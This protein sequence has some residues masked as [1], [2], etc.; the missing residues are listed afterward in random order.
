MQNKVKTPNLT[1]VYSFIQ[2]FYWMNFS[3]VMGFASLYLLLTADLPTQKL[4]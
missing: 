1:F 3:A 2:G 4:A